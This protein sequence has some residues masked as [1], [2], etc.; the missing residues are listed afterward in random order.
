MDIF[1]FIVC[2]ILVAVLVSFTS[3]ALSAGVSLTSPNLI[4]PKEEYRI[5]YAILKKLLK[6]KT[7][8]DLTNPE[9]E[10]LNKFIELMKKEGL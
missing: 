2:F 10:V 1:I 4:V 3:T 6:G 7:K 9:K 5:L 8:K